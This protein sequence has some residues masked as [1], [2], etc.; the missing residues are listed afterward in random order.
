MKILITTFILETPRYEAV[1]TWSHVGGLSTFTSSDFW[2]PLPRREFSIRKDYN[3]LAGTHQLILNPTGWLHLQNNRKVV[4][5]DGKIQKTLATELGAV[6]Y[7]QITTPELTLAAD[8]WKK[9]SPYW[10][11]I[12]KKWSE[13]YAENKEFTLQKRFGGRGLFMHHFAHARELE[14]E[15]PPE[16]EGIIKKGLQTIDDFLSEYVT[17]IRDITVNEVKADLKTENSPTVLDLRTAEEF[18]AGHIEGAVNVD[19]KS[20]NFSEKLKELDRNQRYIVHC[21]SG[22]RSTKALSVFQELHF[23]RIDHLSSGFDGWKK[24]K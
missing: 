5:E 6:R 7:Q 17:E 23:E 18:E 20:D 11:A 15:T 14:Q 24:E 3:V 4:V 8:Y 9:T 2:R 19:F 22:G 1:G 10:D 13:V 16:I 21:K 12:R